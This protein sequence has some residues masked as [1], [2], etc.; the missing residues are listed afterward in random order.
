VIDLLSC[1]K[2]YVVGLLD[3]SLDTFCNLTILV[4]LF[5]LVSLEDKSLLT[6]SPYPDPLLPSLIVVIRLLYLGDVLPS[7]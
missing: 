3:L 2:V 7:F 4:L 6:F 1:D 5:F